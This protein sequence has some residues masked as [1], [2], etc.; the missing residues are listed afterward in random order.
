MDEYENESSRRS[1]QT[2]EAIDVQN[3][4]FFSEYGEFVLA[5]IP[6]AISSSYHL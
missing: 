3:L 4:G 6:G 5:L 2:Q 1:M